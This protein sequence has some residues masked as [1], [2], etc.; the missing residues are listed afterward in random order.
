[1]T[2][3]YNRPGP[4]W[5]RAFLWLSSISQ[6]L[7]NVV[8]SSSMERTNISVQGYQQ[9]LH[10]LS[11]I[12][13]PTFVSKLNRLTQVSYPVIMC[14]RLLD[15][16]SYSIETPYPYGHRSEATIISSEMCDRLEIKVAVSLEMRVV[17]WKFLIGEPVPISVAFVIFTYKMPLEKLWNNE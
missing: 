16:R 17:Y 1:M 5:R 15:L 6:Y 11:Q 13:E 9:F 8:F 2:T 7:T 14:S 12:I 10:W 3:F 4:F